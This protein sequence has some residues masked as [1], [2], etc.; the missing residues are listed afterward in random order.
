MVDAVYTIGHSTHPVE[1]LIA[2]LKQHGITALCDVRSRPYSRMNPQFNRE[3]LKNALREVGIAYVFLGAELGARS[4]DKNCYRDG[5]VQYDLLAR[6]DL[7]RRGIERVKE[8]T[9]LYRLAL[10]CAE[11]EPLDCHRTI[12]VSRSLEE[13]GVPIKHILADGTSE[14]HTHAIERLVKMLGIPSND[15]FRTYDVVVREAYARQANEIAYREQ[16]PESP[17]SAGVGPKNVGRS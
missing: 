9:K 2:L 8:G 12:L 7:F 15:M 11:K 1:K 10:M 14:D 16:S 5:Q 13:D 6:T 4:E 17:A 3:S